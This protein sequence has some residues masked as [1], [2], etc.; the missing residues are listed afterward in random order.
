MNQYL[1]HSNFQHQDPSSHNPTLPT[2]STT[3][4][5]FLHRIQKESVKLRGQC[6]IDNSC[7]VAKTLISS[8]LPSKVIIKPWLLPPFTT[9]L[10]QIESKLET[11]FISISTNSS[12]FDFR[13]RLQNEPSS[14]NNLY[15]DFP[16]SV[17]L[18]NSI[19][20]TPKHPCSLDLHTTSHLTQVSFLTPSSPRQRNS[21][22]NLVV[23]LATPTRILEKDK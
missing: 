5:F 23:F 22:C 20:S 4:S 13:T 6:L 21:L 3:K 1:F 16:E 11:L 9:C 12:C 19:F 14:L 15:L 17:L 18:N 10:Y 2:S 8:Q 7:V